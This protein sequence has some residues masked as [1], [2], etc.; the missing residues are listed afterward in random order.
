MSVA[1]II[2]DIIV[3]VCA[4]IALGLGI[5]NL[6]DW[7]ENSYPWIDIKIKHRQDHWYEFDIINTGKTTAYEVY[8]F[9]TLG[10]GSNPERLYID[11]I[12]PQQSILRQVGFPPAKKGGVYRIET[13]TKCKRKKMF[14]KTDIDEQKKTFDDFDKKPLFT[15]EPKIK[16][17]SYKQSKS[18]K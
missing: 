2:L 4:V 17:I 1:N 10:W 3:G 16:T 5:F 12:K 8:I 18:K 7:F 14:K 13:L 11:N 15:Y 9:I 6:K